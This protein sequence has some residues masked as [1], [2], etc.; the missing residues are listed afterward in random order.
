M[1]KR[2]IEENEIEIKYLRNQLNPDELEAFEVYLMENPEYLETLE[3]DSL[4]LTSE[5]EENKKPSGLFTKL[6]QFFNPMFATALT[7]L[8]I[9]TTVF[10][11]V[12]NNSD[13]DLTEVYVVELENL[14]SSSQLENTNRLYR[15]KI[16]QS[17]RIDLIF[18][19]PE[20]YPTVD[21]KLF[22]AGK[23]PFRGCGKDINVT[24][25]SSVE[26][27]ESK[28]SF[29]VPKSKLGVGEYVVC[30]SSA[31]GLINQYRVSV[32]RH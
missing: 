18:F 4:L 15:N 17:K 13:N 1:D 5:F 22:E 7:T 30:I 11:F 19:L 3:L 31:E 26:L 12:P 14:R 28:Y 21:V 10:V 23:E 29:L 2:Y 24:F 20:E 27:R 9:A 25:E 6:K 16:D 8:V 32:V